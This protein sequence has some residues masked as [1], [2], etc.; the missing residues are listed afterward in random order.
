[1]KGFFYRDKSHR[2]IVHFTHQGR[3]YSFVQALKALCLALPD[4]NK[5][6]QWEEE[7]RLYGDYLKELYQ[8]TVVWFSFRGNSAIHLGMGKAAALIGSYFSDPKLA[9]IAKVQIYWVAG[10]NPFCQPLMYGEGRRYAHQDAN[11]LGE[12]TGELPDADKEPFSF[13]GQMAHHT[14]DVTQEESFELVK[15]MLE[16]FMPLF[17]SRYFNVCADETFDL[18]KGRSKKE[19]ERVGKQELY[20]SFLKRVCNLVVEHGR[21][22]MFW[23]DIICEFPEAVNELPEGTICLNWGYSPTQSAEDTKNFQKAGALQYVCPRVQGWN[24]LVNDS[25]GAYENISRMCHYAKEYG[26]VGVWNTDWG[27]Y[28]H[29]NHPE[30][31]VPGMIYGAAF[32]WNGQIREREEINRA[33]SKIEYGDSSETLV[34]VISGLYDCSVFSW[35]F[36]VAFK[37]RCQKRA[38][39]EAD[40]YDIQNVKWERMEEAEKSFMKG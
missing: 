20:L 37:E 23:G 24:I 6:S 8:M 11:Y 30:F 38:G 36:M 1:M 34:E 40:R 14:V 33:I 28:G 21:I 3:D 32:S 13:L 31:S 2:T 17:T 9:E 39:L 35:F 27:D 22:P 16:E 26:A 15:G 5:R 19:G 10:K 12:M 18:G 7:M 25:K 4:S 29:I